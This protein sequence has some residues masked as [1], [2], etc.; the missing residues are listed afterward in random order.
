MR[1]DYDV[2]KTIESEVKMN[3][4]RYADHASRYK[5]CFH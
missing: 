2:M 3:E 5:I 4:N 1:E